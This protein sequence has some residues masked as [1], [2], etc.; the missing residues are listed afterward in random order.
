M[1][2][3]AILVGITLFI[4]YDLGLIKFQSPVSFQSPIKAVDYVITLPL[5][6]LPPLVGEGEYTQEYYDNLPA[7]EVTDAE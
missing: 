1:T 2:F 4:N 5:P 7:I 6:P 3:A